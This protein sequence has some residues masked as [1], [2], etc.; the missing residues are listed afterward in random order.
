MTFRENYEFFF[1]PVIK[2][3]NSYPHNNAIY[4]FQMY[5]SAKLSHNPNYTYL[6]PIDIDFNAIKAF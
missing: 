4:P 3:S 5:F 6:S 2:F 1:F